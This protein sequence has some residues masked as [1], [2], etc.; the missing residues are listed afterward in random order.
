MLFYICFFN[1]YN[2]IGALPLWIFNT[3]QC[4]VYFSF[5]CGRGGGDP[6]LRLQNYRYGY[7]VVCG[8]NNPLCKLLVDSGWPWRVIVR[9]VGS[10]R[11][12]HVEYLW[13][14]CWGGG[15]GAAHK[16]HTNSSLLFIYF[17]SNDILSY[18]EF[19]ADTVQAYIGLCHFLK[20][21]LKTFV[22]QIAERSIVTLLE[23]HFA[24]KIGMPPQKFGCPPTSITTRDVCQRDKSIR[25]WH[26]IVIH[27]CRMYAVDLPSL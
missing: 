26:A 13:R 3:C 22:L 8:M 20:T 17:C 14:D 18:E 12:Y 5:F 9:V 27:W 7:V 6:A 24:S 11:K 2:L 23:K 15:G 21:S 16:N 1:Y 19:A 10:S 25:E 4:C